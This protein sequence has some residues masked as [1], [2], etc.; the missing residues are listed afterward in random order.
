MMTGMIGGMLQGM[1][2]G[3]MGELLLQNTCKFQAG[4]VG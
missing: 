2:W 4:G 1:F 3:I